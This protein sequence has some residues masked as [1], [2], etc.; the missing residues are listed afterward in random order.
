MPLNPVTFL[1][2]HAGCKAVP[3]MLLLWLLPLVA[4][5]SAVMH[6]CMI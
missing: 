6:A 4:T 3:A 1:I 2:L 5:Y